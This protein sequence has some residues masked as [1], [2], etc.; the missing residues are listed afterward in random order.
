MASGQT[1]IAQWHRFHSAPQGVCRRCHR[2]PCVLPAG[3]AAIYG[4]ARPEGRRRSWRR[5]SVLCRKCFVSSVLN[6]YDTRHYAPSRLQPRGLATTA[7]RVG[8]YSRE[9]SR[10]QSGV[11]TTTVGSGHDYSRE[12]WRGN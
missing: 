1:I 11:V 7:R 4:Q 6:T 12:G 9:W 5:M 10:L 2:C 8:D 3:R